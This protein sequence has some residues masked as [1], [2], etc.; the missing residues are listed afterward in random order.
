MNMKKK[1]RIGDLTQGL[2]SAQ[3]EL[4]VINKKIV[5]HR[6]AAKPISDEAHEKKVIDFMRS[7]QFILASIGTIEVEWQMYMVD[8]KFKSP[9]M[10]NHLKR[11]RESMREVKRHFANFVQVKDQDEFSYE[12]TVQLHRV[13]ALFSG[14]HTDQL[15]EYADGLEELLANTTESHEK[16]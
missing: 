5:T 16:T 6:I 13:M 7:V 15:S 8:Y 12:Y 9:N 14:L 4:S 1:S 3:A 10:N 2:H 11:M